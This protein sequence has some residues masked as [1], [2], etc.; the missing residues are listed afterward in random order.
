MRISDW[1]S[2]VCSSDL[3]FA[4]WIPREPKL[5]DR[6]ADRI[7]GQFSPTA[8]RRGRLS[9]AANSAAPALPRAGPE[10]DLLRQPAPLLGVVGRDHRIIGRQPPALPI[11]LRRHVAIGRASC[12]ERVCQYV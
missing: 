5:M 7:I 4:R 11:F 10:T 8:Y 2:D 12:R 6:P 1:S 3:W 9:G